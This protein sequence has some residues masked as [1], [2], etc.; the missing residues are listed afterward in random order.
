MQTSAKGEWKPADVSALLRFAGD[1]KSFT[2]DAKLY[3]SPK[4]EGEEKKE[5]KERK[6]KKEAAKN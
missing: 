3:A 2:W 1:L 4:A 6:E 5:R